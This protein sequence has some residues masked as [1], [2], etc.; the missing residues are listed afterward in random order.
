MMAAMSADLD[1][2][3]YRKQSAALR[4]EIERIRTGN[5][6]SG[7][8]TLVAC[9]AELSVFATAIVDLEAK[10]AWGAEGEMDAALC[11]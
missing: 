11:P 7:D 9:V 2:R 8:R 3:W 5:R 1:L 6:R 10:N 4:L